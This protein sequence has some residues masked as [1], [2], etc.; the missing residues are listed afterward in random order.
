MTPEILSNSSFDALL[1]MNHM[2]YD[3]IS[4]S[5]VKVNNYFIVTAFPF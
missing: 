3:I 4:H 5:S 2:I 1:R